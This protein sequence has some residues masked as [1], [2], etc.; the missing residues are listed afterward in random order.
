MLSSAVESADTDTLSVTRCVCECCLYRCHLLCSTMCMD[1]L[2]SHHAD[3]MLCCF[4]YYRTIVKGLVTLHYSTGTCV[5]VRFCNN[6]C[7]SNK[8]FL[9]NISY[10]W[11]PPW[12]GLWPQPFKTPS[13]NSACSLAPPFS[14]PAAALLTPTHFC[15]K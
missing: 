15:L 3:V 8:L 2:A 4:N 14:P 6:Y 1:C 13:H 10:A 9:F 11:K 5:I 7:L 12:L